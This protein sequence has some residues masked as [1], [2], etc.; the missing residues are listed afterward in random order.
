MYNGVSSLRRGHAQ[1]DPPC[2]CHPMQGPCLH[3]W[4]NTDRKRKTHSQVSHYTCSCR[5][6]ELMA[7]RYSVIKAS[8]LH[9]RGC[10]NR[11]HPNP[12]PT[13]EKVDRGHLEALAAKM[14]TL[15][16]L[17]IQDTCPYQEI[18]VRIWPWHVLAPTCFV[19]IF[20]LGMINMYCLSWFL[21][22]AGTMIKHQITTCREDAWHVS[23]R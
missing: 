12:S 2:A 1:F 23:G 4:T 3:M 10:S 18:Q 14:F 7:S 22:D 15:M 9:I 6:F 11:L 20:S 13:K 21:R 17:Q 16:L 5:D 8:F 19:D